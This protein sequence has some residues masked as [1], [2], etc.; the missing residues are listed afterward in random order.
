M[1]YQLRRLLILLSLISFVCWALF[2]FLGLQSYFMDVP[3]SQSEVEGAYRG[4]VL[5]WDGAIGDTASCLAA[6]PGFGDT[7]VYAVN[8]ARDRQGL[9]ML[10][11][12]PVLS[13][14]ARCEATAMFDGDYRSFVTP[15]GSHLD[16]RLATWVRNGF[17]AS[18]ALWAE[19][20]DSGQTVPIAAGD[21]VRGW[22]S[23]TSQARVLGGPDYTRAGAGV[24]KRDGRLLAVLI[25]YEDVL[26]LKE[27]LP[28]A[29]HPDSTSITVSGWKHG[30][31]SLDEIQPALLKQERGFFVRHAMTPMQVE[32]RSQDEWFE[33]DLSFGGDGLYLLRLDA[34][35][36]FLDT[37]P[38]R[39]E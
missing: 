33:M 23:T 26:I 31:F 3:E 13:A 15:D 35:G 22:A 21:I 25:L 12:D 1:S 4:P 29:L 18:T 38:I 27:D 39:V 16:E 9:D 10:P 5:S 37:H 24:V 6:S 7:L 20:S 11:V 19:L 8:W 28:L 34:G 32:F 30:R 17:G 36:D 2:I 14:A